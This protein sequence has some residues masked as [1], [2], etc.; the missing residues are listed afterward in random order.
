MRLPLA[1][2]AVCLVAAIGAAPAAA[3]P[4][5]TEFPLPHAGSGPV[6]TTLRPGGLLQWFTEADGNRIG[7]ISPTRLNEFSA[8]L[9]PGARPSHMAATPDR[10]IW[11]TEPGVN[12]VGRIDH[13]TTEIFEFSTGIT[14]GAGPDAITAGPDG[15]AWFTET[16][17]GHI[18]RVNSATGEITEFPVLAPPASATGIAAGPDGALWFTQPSLDR[19][20]RMTLDGTMTPFSLPAGRGPTGIAAGPDGALW[21]TEWPGNRIGRI[22]TA[23]E[24]TEFPALRSGAHPLA[25]TT[26]PDGNVWFTETGANRIG[27]INGQGRLTH[28]DAGISPGSG[29]ADIGPG[30]DNAVWFVETAGNRMGRIVVGP[31][32]TTGAAS[33]VTATGATIAGKVRPNGQ[34]TTYWVSYGPTTDYGA[35]SAR[36]QI[37]AGPKPVNITRALTGLTP[38]TTYHYRLVAT[39]ATDTTRGEDRTFTTP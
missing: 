23:G 1:L 13:N 35:R 10:W 25:I 31:G 17:G 27:R 3:T 38:G 24:V 5:I 39:N 29:L 34:D 19:I 36:G 8:G 18:G 26:G 14:P 20:V 6:G 37:P 16:L 28:Y 33:A 22:T 32:A 4:T 21:F 12:K 15:N 30:Q 2:A 9:S 11:F 7:R